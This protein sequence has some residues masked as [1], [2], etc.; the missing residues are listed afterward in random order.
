MPRGMRL[1]TACSHSSL[2]PR[3]IIVDG[4]RTSIRLE[5]AMWDALNEIVE[6]EGI[7][8]SEFATAVDRARRTS[9]LTA[10]IRVHIMEYFREA[11][12][13]SGHRQAG[14]GAFRRR[15]RTQANAS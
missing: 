3:N 1:D 10:A 7:T 8:A 2:V 14:H 11:T 4:R 15:Y 5:Q 12:T 6:R 9:T 13:E